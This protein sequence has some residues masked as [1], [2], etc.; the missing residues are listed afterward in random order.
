M[1]QEQ[2]NKAAQQQIPVETLLTM[3]GEQAVEN[4][5]LRTQLSQLS[6]MVERLR[7]EKAGDDA[8]K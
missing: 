1:G 7:A 8:E 2:Q 5:M 3:I 6:Q 4:R